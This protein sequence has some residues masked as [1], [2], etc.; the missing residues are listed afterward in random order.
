MANFNVQVR[1]D[2][3]G[4]RTG[5]RAVQ[6]ELQ[7]IENSAD[8]VRGAIAQALTFV[9]VGLGIREITNYADTFVN[10]QNRLRTVTSGT[11]EL[12]AVTNE[13]FRI[14][15]QTRSSFA[16]TTEVYARTALA[17]RELGVS[18]ATTLAFTES[19]NQAV[20]LSG[21]SA[22]EANAALIQLSQ[23]LASNTLRGDELRSVLEQLPVVADVIA[24]ELGVTR[25][26]LREL[27]ADGQITADIIL[28]AF[29]NA[30]EE[31]AGRFAQAIPTISQSFQILQNNV[32]RYIG[33]LDNSLGITRTVSRTIIFLS[34][35][36]AVLARGVAALGIAFSVSLAQRG[37]GAAITAFR[38][39]AVII[40]ANPLGAL[41]TGITLVVSALVPFAERIKISSDG[42]VTLR[43]V[44][45]ATFQVIS[46]RI[47]PLVIMLR[48]GFEEAITSVINAFAG[49][50]I[51]FEDVLNAARIFVNRWIG[52]YV[53]LAQAISVVFNG[54]RQII[55][56][57][58]ATD[59]FQIVQ[60]G[61]RATVEFILELLRAVGR[62]AQF[63]LEQLG[64][65]AQ[66]LAT[67]LEVAFDLPEQN[68]INRFVNFG[69]DVR[70]AFLDGFGR[71][72]VGEF[73]G[74]T[75]PLFNEIGNRAREIAQE[76]AAEAAVTAAQPAVEAD[77]GQIAAPEVPIQQAIESSN[78]LA[79]EIERLRAELI[80]GEDEVTI[81]L[82]EQL[83]E[84]QEIFQEALD[85]R[86]ISEQEFQQ[87]S[88]AANEQYNNAI[89]NNEL[90]RQR[91]Q[92]TSAS[93][94]FGQLAGVA[95][96]FRGRQSRTYRTLFNISKAF[97][98]AESSVAVIQAIANATRTGFPQ[99]II[100]I[101]ST[102]AQ[103][104][105]LVAQIRSTQFA[106][107]FQTGGAFD[108]EGAGG[109][110]SQLV[111]FR[112]TPGERVIVQT[113]GQRR[114][115]EAAP[116]MQQAQPINI[117]NL[118][119]PNDLGDY[120][121]TPDGEEVLVNAINRNRETIQG[122]LQN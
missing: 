119:N 13:L 80:R 110:D 23:G 10:L 32:I 26:E 55:I 27:G 45:I 41:L 90:N 72:F 12:N 30:R 106:G 7:L 114:Q 51:T 63:I 111:S 93:N 53:G 35:N 49:L 20:L 15:N 34:E 88:L 42:L 48:E 100:N 19:L 109:A 116:V 108:V 85:T 118:T 69:G 8:R 112:A 62:L 6:R 60:A 76:R 91:L 86:L 40:A 78:I 28:R 121:N 73:L 33:D 98:I 113:P 81:R 104:A 29:V 102:L 103:T 31:L 22:Q 54:I 70:D 64:I 68:I 117:V 5:R 18:Q 59:T 67:A 58:V 3:R 14:S 16:A 65:L 84:R 1:I 105:G 115:A 24:Q 47:G 71:D 52:L 44:A 46:E 38:A 56:D 39:L 9:G 11:A 101:A 97:A 36:I 122:Q 89:L 96:T 61:A 4:A 66:D 92:L 57:V 107:G 25:G 50:G 87:L 17:V 95:E 120:L 77:L 83:L 99:N 79:Q 43:D 21:A 94:T 2:P 74:V 82:G 75:D 37:I